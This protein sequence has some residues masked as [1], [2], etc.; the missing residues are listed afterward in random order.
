[1]PLKDFLNHL[2]GKSSDVHEWEMFRPLLELFKTLCW[3]QSLEF[4]FSTFQFDM[5]GYKINTTANG[6][7]IEVS[8]DGSTWIQAHQINDN[9]TFHCQIFPIVKIHGLSKI[10]LTFLN[11][12]W[13]NVTEFDIFWQSS[14]FPS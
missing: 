4:S 9:T 14:K 11:S 6:W 13:Q 2:S 3:N 12:Q 7:I 8:I 1:L 10:R 5:I